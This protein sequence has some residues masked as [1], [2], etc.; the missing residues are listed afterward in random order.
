M[1]HP[2]DP[3]QLAVTSLGDRTV[4]GTFLFGSLRRLCGL[5]F[6]GSLCLGVFFG[7]LIEFGDSRFR[8]VE[9][10]M[11]RVTRYEFLERAAGLPGI[12]Q[13][14]LVDLANRKQGV[15]AVL[16]AGIFAPQKSVLLDGGV[17]NFVIIE[18]AAHLDQQFGSRYYAGIGFARCRRTEVDAAVSINHA[19]VVVA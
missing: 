16:A 15:E 13:I 5:R 3:C 2:G 11:P 18:L 6:P 7:C 12:V 4:L 14:V 19:L 8:I 1:A 9:Q 17:K 10:M